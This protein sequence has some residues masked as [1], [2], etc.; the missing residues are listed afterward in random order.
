MQTYDAAKAIVGPERGQKVDEAAEEI[1]R[2]LTLLG[3][4]GVE[5][6]LQ[7]GVPETIDKLAKVRT[8][9]T[10]QHARRFVL[11]SHRYT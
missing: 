10:V 3:C 9:Q 7:A 1:E 4:S 5:D 2:D 6:K 8:S 11:R